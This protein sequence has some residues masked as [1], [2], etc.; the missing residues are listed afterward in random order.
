MI[1]TS[2]HSIKSTAIVF[3][4]LQ[5]RNAKIVAIKKKVIMIYDTP[6]FITS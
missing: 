4:Y 3:S 5:I 2:F 1:K 6:S